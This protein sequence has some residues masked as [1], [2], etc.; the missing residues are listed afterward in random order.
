M[1]GSALLSHVTRI[2]AML[3][4][5]SMLIKYGAIFLSRNLARLDI[6]RKHLICAEAFFVH[7]VG[8][9]LGFTKSAE[10]IHLHPQND[11]FS[12][13]LDLGHSFAHGQHLRYA[14]ALNLEPRANLFLSSLAYLLSAAN[15]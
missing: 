8:V 7:D 14:R 1:H 2:V 10:S 5:C 12:S 6:R 13:S 15:R 3:L 9:H 4:S 11:P